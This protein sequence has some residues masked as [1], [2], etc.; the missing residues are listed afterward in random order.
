M[1]VTDDLL[2]EGDES[3]ALAAAFFRAHL[4]SASSATLL[5]S[6]SQIMTVSMSACSGYSAF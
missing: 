2:V 6:L 3:V 1:V 4:G 5:L